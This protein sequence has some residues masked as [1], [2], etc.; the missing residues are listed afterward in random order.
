[1]SAIPPPPH[2][3]DATEANFQSEVLDA[4]FDQPILVD[5]WATWCGPCKVL[6]PLLEKVVGEFNGAIRLAKIDCDKEQALAA[7]FGVRSIPTVV[8]IREGQLVDAFTGALPEGAIREFLARHVQPG[9]AAPEQAAPPL[10]QET[11]EQAIAR[12]QQAIAAD[13][14]KAEL[15]LELAVAQMQAGNALAAEAE[16]DTL[17]ANLAGD[18]RAKRLRGQLDF[19]RSLEGAPD[20][21]ELRARIERDPGD[22]AARDLLGV[23]LLIDGD[24][25]SA[26]D[27]FLAILAADRNW[28]EGQAKKRLIAAFNVLDDADLVGDYRRRMSSLLF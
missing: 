7:S 17:P 27:Q 13:P 28:N 8:L 15:K 10:R 6:G 1:M 14:D 4:S 9:E 26:L 16:L 24:A 25:A 2:V 3:F 12:L 19:A 5:L 21:T 18:D 23:R 11:P 20:A 22:H